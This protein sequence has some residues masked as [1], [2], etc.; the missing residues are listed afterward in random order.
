[1]T[2]ST[3]RAPRKTAASA[4]RAT[5]T[6]V[7]MPVAV[8]GGPA[9]LIDIDELMVTGQECT[10]NCWRLPSDDLVNRSAVINL[11]ETTASTGFTL[12]FEAKCQQSRSIAAFHSPGGR[13]RL[14]RV[15]KLHSL[16]ENDS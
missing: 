10:L 5:A 6:T 9:L 4:P 11:G 15:L 3:R 12:T 1:M 2:R 16:C 13:Q 14:S 8:A 7:S